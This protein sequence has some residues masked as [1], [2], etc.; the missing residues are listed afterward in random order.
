[1]A[2]PDIASI[3]KASM[4][5]NK[6]GLH[7]HKIDLK[8]TDEREI[9]KGFM[10]SLQRISELNL[11]DKLKQK[12][13]D[14]YNEC[15]VYAESGEHGEKTN[16]FDRDR[17]E[18]DLYDLDFEEIEN[19]LVQNEIEIDTELDAATFDDNQDDIVAE[20]LDIMEARTAESESDGEPK[21]IKAD[22]N[23]RA[24]LKEKLLALD[25]KSLKNYIKDNSALKEKFGII[26]MAEFKNNFDDIVNGILDIE[27]SIV[28]ATEDNSSDDTTDDIASG[29]HEK[30][31][32]MDYKTVKAFLK[33]N[34][35]DIKIILKNW[36]NPAEKE[37]IILEIVGCLS[38]VET[39]YDRDTEQEKLE[40]MTCEELQA[41]VEKNNLVD[42]ITDIDPETFEDEQADLIDQI[43]DVLDYREEE[44]SDPKTA[45]NPDPPKEKPDPK[46]AAKSTSKR[47]KKASNDYSVDGDTLHHC[48]A[49]AIR[50]FKGEFSQEEISRVAE[51]ER[52]KLGKKPGSV[53]NYAKMIIT[54]CFVMGFLKQG[55]KSGYFS[56][57]K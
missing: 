18:S 27:C 31:Y 20:I 13:F 22:D 44:K 14:L 24:D 40:S 56:L 1:M 26:K 32:K 38:P 4:E 12:H 30:L 2:M 16:G 48:I 41:Y 49:R 47:G 33:E 21:E 23:A 51:A 45:E 5:I 42:E 11:E 17:L 46:P 36:K 57:K 34:E 39:T 43:L 10:A 52:T 37:K 15:L 50:D 53:S 3:K 9:I 7:E 55:K 29:W 35:L 8:E 54:A 6:L 28:E 19:Y 25:F